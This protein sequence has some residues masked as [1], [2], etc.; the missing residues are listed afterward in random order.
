MGKERSKDGAIFNDD[1]TT[2]SPADRDIFGDE[3]AANPAK[4]ET[5]PRVDKKPETSEAGG[6][7]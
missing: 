1:A 2:R 3:G 4:D 6:V 7:D 5:P